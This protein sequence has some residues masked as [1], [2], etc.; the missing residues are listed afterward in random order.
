MTTFFNSLI[1]QSIP[2]VSITNILQDCDG[3][4]ISISWMISPFVLVSA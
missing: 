2:A 3:I 4:M 1:T